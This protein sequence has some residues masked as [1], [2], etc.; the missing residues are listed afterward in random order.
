MASSPHHTGSPGNPPVRHA[1]NV[2]AGGLEGRGREVMGSQRYSPQVESILIPWTERQTDRR[3]P[4][5]LLAWLSGSPGCPSASVTLGSCRRCGHRLRVPAR[6]G[7]GPAPTS[8]TQACMYRDTPTQTRTP[9]MHPC[10]K[11]TRT[12][13]CT[14]HRQAPHPSITG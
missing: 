3:T 12:Q 5:S 2:L 1:E 9:S 10:R 13:T 8:H 7:L 14:V 11:H 6:G 4:T